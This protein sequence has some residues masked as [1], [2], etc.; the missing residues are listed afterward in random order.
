MN[1]HDPI[2]A[3]AVLL[4]HLRRHAVRTDGP[5]T[6]RSGAISDWYLDARQSLYSGEAS[7]ACG[8]ALLD[9]LA[10]YD[11]DAV[12]GM[13]MGADPVALATAIAGELS[14][15]PLRAFS[16]RKDDKGHGG[17][18]R[19]AGPL[20]AGDRVA[21][22]EDT[23]TTGGALFEAVEVVRAAGGRPVVL[24]V[25]V[26]RSNGDVAQRAKEF[27]LPL[28]ALFQPADLGRTT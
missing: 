14:G 2:G 26:D 23:A 24:A 11:V 16:V 8:I 1:L 18:G 7:L 10:R 17:G 3:R 6:L 25:V 12:G 13:T 22:V 5:F 28:V 19:I 4:D 9:A 20:A 27:G 21:V 15:A